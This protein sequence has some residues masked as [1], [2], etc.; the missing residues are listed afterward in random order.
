M[1]GAGGLLAS[2]GAARFARAAAEGAS[3][4]AAPQEMFFGEHQRGIATA[5][6][7]NS[8]FVA[9]DLVAKSRDEV[10]AMLRAWT[11]AAA[12]MTSGETARPLGQDLSVEGPDGASALGLTRAR[13]TITF[14]FG[15][16]LFAKDGVDRYGLAGKRPDALVDLP[17][18]NGDQLQ[19]ARTGGDISVQACADDPQVVFHAVRELDRL[20]YGAAQI[21][22]AQTGFLPHTP[23]GE[24]PRNLMGFKDGTVNP[25]LGGAPTTPDAPR[26]FDDVV[27]VGEEGPD[28]M[29]GGSYVV[30]RRIRISLEHWDRTEVDFQEQVIGRHKYSG[31]PIGKSGEQEPLDLDREDKDGNPLIA[32]NAHVRLGAPTV[33]EGAQILRRAYSYNDGV[34]FTA[35][36][37]P[38]WRQGMLYDAGLF[39]VS[40][41]RDPRAGFIKIYDN[42]AKLDALSQFTTHTGGGLFACPGGVREGEFVGRRLF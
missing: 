39:F 24:T 23:P 7:A 21:R 30:A 14:G 32:D 12:R 35:E 36:R 34:S 1:A 9:F 28:W 13:L 8:Y 25:P 29:R 17:R 18:F 15:A 26:G 20:S 41:Q 3:T 5:Q 31:A 6:Q 33:N 22:W 19:A 10:T 11:E 40:Y 2:A 16:G 42:M 38:P 4:G 27:W 37:W